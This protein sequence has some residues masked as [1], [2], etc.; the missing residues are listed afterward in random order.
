MKKIALVGSGTSAIGFLMRFNQ[1]SQKNITIDCFEQGKDLQERIQSN[2]V[3][4]GFGGAGTFSDGK[5]SL[6]PEIGG[7]ICDLIGM[8]KYEEYIDDVVELWTRGKKVEKANIGD[9]RVKQLE[10]GFRQNNLLLRLSDFYH[11]G[12]DLLQEIL[13]EIKVDLKQKSDMIHFHFNQFFDFDTIDDYD[14]VVIASGRY[15]NKSSKE[16][17]KLLKRFEIDYKENKID[18]GIRYEVPSEITDWLTDLLYEFKVLGYSETEEI[19][20]TFCV[21]PKGYVVGEGGNDFSLVN[22]HSYL[23]KKSKNT[24]FAILVTQKFTEPFKDAY[25]YGST[26]SVLANKLAGTGK[27][28]VQ[29]YGD[30]ISG[31]RTTE[32]RLQKGFLS[33]TLET[34]SPGDLNLIL[35]RRI[36]NSIEHFIEQMSKVITGINNPDNLLYGIEAKF[37]STKPIFNEPFKLGKE[38]VYLIGDASGY[39]RGIVQATMSGIYIADIIASKL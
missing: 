9:E 24:N 39:T 10:L 31:R 11:I 32:R 7:D 38:N 21:N 3:I 13:K 2:D 15:D 35:P 28:L 17:Q 23:N 37:Y 6:S 16:I 22:G 29:R 25:V 36:A 8:K 27:I 19:V 14:Y 4:T 20:R 18:I 5:L 12:T 34:A 33:P 30:F 1:N 26:L